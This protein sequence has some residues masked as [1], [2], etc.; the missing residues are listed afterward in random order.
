M[1]FE[2]PHERQ[3]QNP[4]VTEVDFQGYVIRSQHV[5]DVEHVGRRGEKNAELVNLID[6]LD[7]DTDLNVCEYLVDLGG[8]FCDHF[9]TVRRV[10]IRRGHAR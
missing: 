7:H 8:I 4:H 2:Q 1:L 3:I 9:G 10:V 5:D 6:G